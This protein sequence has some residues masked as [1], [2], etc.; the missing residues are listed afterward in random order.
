MEELG[1]RVTHKKYGSGMINKIDGDFAEVSFG[2]VVKQFKFPS[3][4]FDGYL[5]SEDDM[6]KTLV[7]QGL[8]KTF[9]ARRS[10]SALGKIP[11]VEPSQKSMSESPET[12]VP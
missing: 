6:R 8:S 10:L 1:Y 5:A 4:F 12:H 11:I 3:C 2:T 7:M 9:L